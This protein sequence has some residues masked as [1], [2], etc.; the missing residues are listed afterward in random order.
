MKIPKFEVETLKLTKECKER[1]LGFGCP[2]I[3]E[4]DGVVF[5]DEDLCTGCG[6]CAQLCPGVIKV[7]G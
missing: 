1:L 3:V 5:I 4:E 7:K 2:A 6:V